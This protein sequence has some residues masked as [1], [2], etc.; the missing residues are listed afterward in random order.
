M[1]FRLPLPV[2]DRLDA[3]AEREGITR[4]A[5]LVRLVARYVESYPLEDVD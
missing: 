4:S 5:I 1:T 3:I 2:K